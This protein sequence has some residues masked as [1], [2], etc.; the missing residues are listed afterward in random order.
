MVQEGLEVALSDLLATAVPA[1]IDSRVSARGDESS[2]PD[3]IKEE[4]F[5][6]LREAVRNAVA[7]SKARQ[8]RVDLSTT[9]Q[10]I[11]AAVSDDGCGFDRYSS[12]FVA[13]TGLH[14]MEERL[15]LLGGTLVVRSNSAGTRVEANVSLTGAG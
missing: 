5:L 14:A 6:V 9:A 1:G 12:G 7:H 13:G 8:I 4:L 15:H 3:C 10:R 2:V 11:W